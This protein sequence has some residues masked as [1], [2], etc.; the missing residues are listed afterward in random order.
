MVLRFSD[1][2]DGHTIARQGVWIQKLITFDWFEPY[3][4]KFHQFFERSIVLFFTPTQNFICW[5]RHLNLLWPRYELNRSLCVVC[6]LQTLC[7]NR[8][9]QFYASHWF[10]FQLLFAPM[11]RGCSKLHPIVVFLLPS[12]SPPICPKYSA[13][14]SFSANNS[15]CT[16][17]SL[18]A[19]PCF[20][21]QTGRNISRLYE[22][23]KE[24]LFSGMMDG[25]GRAQSLP[26]IHRPPLFPFPSHRIS[27]R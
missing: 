13:S 6:V 21:V 23:E 22:E 4:H 7:R 17:S 5:K 1:C 20:H 8:F 3:L 16:V 14:Y 24:L 11:F 2:R 18:A 12:S 25:K 15:I 19:P 26:Y 10:T 9:R 27:L